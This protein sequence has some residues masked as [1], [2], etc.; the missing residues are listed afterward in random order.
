MATE[1]VTILEF[2]R[3]HPVSRSLVGKL[4]R[5]GKIPRVC[6]SPGQH[7]CGKWLVRADAWE[8]LEAQQAEGQG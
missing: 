6:A 1:W 8:T 5:E 3:R 4:A 7:K 2:C